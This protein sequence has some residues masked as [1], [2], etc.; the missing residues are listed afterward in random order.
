[1]AAV[2]IPLLPYHKLAAEIEY[3]L[4]LLESH[5]QTHPDRHRTIRAVFDYSWKQLTAKE[6]ELFGRLSIFHG[7]FEQDAAEQVAQASL[8]LL[9]KLVSKSLLHV[10]KKTNRY[11]LHPL[12]RQYA[13]EKLAA[14]SAATATAAHARFYCGWLGEQADKLHGKEQQTAVQAIALDLNN[15]RAAWQWATTKQA[16]DLL[17]Q[18]A[19]P[20]AEFCEMRGLFVEG[21]TMLAEATAQ[22]RSVLREGEEDQT[23]VVVAK[24][25]GWQGW[26]NFLNGRPTTAKKH[27][28]EAIGILRQ[29]ET[30]A[31]LVTPI[32]QLAYIHFCTDDYETAYRLNQESKLLAQQNGNLFGE[33]RAARTEASLLNAKG[34]YE[35][36]IAMYEQALESYRILGN[37]QGI[38]WSLLSISTVAGEMGA[39]AKAKMMAEEVV[40]LSRTINFQLVEGYALLG[41]G[42]NYAQHQNYTQAIHIFEEALEVGR[43]IRD[44]RQESRVLNWLGTCWRAQQKYDAARRC[45]DQALTIYRQTNNQLGE[46]LVLNDLGILERQL[47]HFKKS[48]SYHRQA[49]AMSQAIG[50][51]TLQRRILSSLG[52]WYTAQEQDNKAQQMFE[53]AVQ[54][55]AELQP[56]QKLPPLAGLAYLAA[57]QE[58]TAVAERYLDDIDMMLQKYPIDGADEPQRVAWYI[59]QA[60]YLAGRGEL[61]Q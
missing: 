7:S 53:E 47:G 17:A 34:K 50:N 33:A 4:D 2:W 45:Y 12:L 28:R 39:Y 58:R 16:E 11:G 22:L 43:L 60:N 8:P 30:K 32:N 5:N 44:Q 52:H 10:D 19:A 18:A 57:K 20:L 9:I 36:T 37:E 15:I 21:G 31:A 35:D 38:C 27:L 54:A 29:L 42:Y 46:G 14:A 26:M 40:E 59:E 13:A 41:L 24:L 56:P 55:V 25:Q 6:Q 61:A 51:Q 3:N 23:A 1:M 49:L 48:R